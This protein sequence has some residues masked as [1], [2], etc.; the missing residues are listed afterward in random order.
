M[1]ENRSKR[2]NKEEEEDEP[3]QE[4][5]EDDEKQKPVS[6]LLQCSYKFLP[7]K[8]RILQQLISGLAAHMVGL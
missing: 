8:D 6:V 4:E 7:H 5:E 1:E 3:E 2:K